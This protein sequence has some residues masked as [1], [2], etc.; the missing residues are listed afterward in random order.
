MKKYVIILCIVLIVIGSLLL[1]SNNKNSE[2]KIIDNEV[3]ETMM[4]AKDLMNLFDE[5]EARFYKLYGGALIEF[6]GTVKSVSVD[7]QV[8]ISDNKISSNQNKI[9][10]EEGWCLIIGENNEQYD[11][12]TF[13][14]G[15]KLKVVTGIATTPYSTDFVKQVCDNQRVVW[16]V[17]NDIIHDEQY[18]DIQT[19]IQ[20]IK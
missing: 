3:T 4:T 13:N 15:D 19:M 17:G 5:N 12:S 1:I 9:V 11:L 10:F 8:I 2:A 14:K 6:E 16:L 7:T 20:K 18:N